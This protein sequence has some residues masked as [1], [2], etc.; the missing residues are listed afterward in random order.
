LE[1]E[2]KTEG[3]KSYTKKGSDTKIGKE[4]NKRNETVGEKRSFS[5]FR[6]ISE[7]K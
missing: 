1:P 7:K 6:S 4:Q 2:V 5:A 3:K